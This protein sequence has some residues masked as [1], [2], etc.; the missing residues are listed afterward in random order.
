M[1]Y[2]APWSKKV[3]EPLLYRFLTW[4]ILQLWRWRRYDTLKCWA[5]SKLYGVKPHKT[6]LFMVAAVRT[7]S[8]SLYLIYLWNFHYMNSSVFRRY[9]T[10][11]CTAKYVSYIFAHFSQKFD[12]CQLQ[13]TPTTAC[14][15]FH[16]FQ[17]ANCFMA[18]HWSYPLLMQ[19]VS[20]RASLCRQHYIHR[21][22]CKLWFSF[23]IRLKEHNFPSQRRLDFNIAIF[24]FRLEGITWY[25]FSKTV[26]KHFGQ[27]CY[28]I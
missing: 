20:S 24:M 28:T 18:S 27:F 3:W 22:V 1:F 15:I 6:V 8:N 10:P 16:H 2:S 25:H 9:L 26:S 7:A 19:H 13:N 14:S 23:S 21:S 4:V 12:R 5:L 11:M 17:F